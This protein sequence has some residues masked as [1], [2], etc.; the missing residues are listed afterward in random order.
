MASP[1][2]LKFDYGTYVIILGSKF[3]LLLI[4]N[5]RNTTKIRHIRDDT[6]CDIVHSSNNLA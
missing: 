5:N 3:E 1:I 4:E 6:K 2:S